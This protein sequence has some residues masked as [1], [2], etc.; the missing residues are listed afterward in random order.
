MRN[1]LINWK[2]FSDFTLVKIDA[3]EGIFE[4]KILFDDFTLQASTVEVL[5]HKAD[6]LFIVALRNLFPEPKR[7]WWRRKIATKFQNKIFLE[8]RPP[9]TDCQIIAANFFRRLLVKNSFFLFI[10]QKSSQHDLGYLP[11]KNQNKNERTINKF[12]RNEKVK[13]MSSYT[14]TEEKITIFFF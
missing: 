2:A 8:Q 12:K 1:K 10:K 7:N 5:L 4:F 14:R 11:K 9:K 3:R 6:P 13:Q